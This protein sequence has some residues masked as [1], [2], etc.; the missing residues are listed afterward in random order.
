MFSDH[1]RI[2]VEINNR[3]IVEKSPNAWKLNNIL[4]NNLRVK[5]QVSREN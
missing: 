5:E 1:T 4:L 3:K 2:K